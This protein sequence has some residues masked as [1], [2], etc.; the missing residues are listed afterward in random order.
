MSV[1]EDRP[2]LDYI[3]PLLKHYTDLW[4]DTRGSAME[5]DRYIAG[6]YP[7]WKPGVMQSS[8]MLPMP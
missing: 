4:S 7:L 5:A 6:N 2:T 8:L 3:G 1:F